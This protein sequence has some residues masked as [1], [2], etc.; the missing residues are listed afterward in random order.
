MTKLNP[1]QQKAARQ[2]RQPVNSSITKEQWAQIKTEL[3]SYFCHIEFKYGDTV[4]TVARERDGESR[5]VLAV[6]FDGTMRGAWGSEK[7]EVYNPITRLFWCEK[8]KRLYS[9]KRA[10]QLEKEI[11]KRRAKEHFPDL[12]DSYSYWLPFFSSSTSLIRQFKKAEGLTWVNNAGG[13]D[14]A[15]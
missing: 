4:I 10:A 7:S 14:D 5:T 12:H 1:N 3:Q 2:R 15:S 9:A 11:G 6:Y 8:K 13:A